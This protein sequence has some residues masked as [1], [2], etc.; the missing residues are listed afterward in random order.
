MTINP[1]T[2]DPDPTWMTRLEALYL[3]G[4]REVS[5]GVR[6][7]L[8]NLATRYSPQAVYNAL[9][10]AELNAVAN[11]SY[12]TELLSRGVTAQTPITTRRQIIPDAAPNPDEVTP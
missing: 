2:N 6:R 12:V 9:R 4:G 5:P 7:D 8:A 11:I 10:I 1:P 3:A